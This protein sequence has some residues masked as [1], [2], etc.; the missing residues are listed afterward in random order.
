MRRFVERARKGQRGQV[1]P[2]FALMALM[3]VGAVALAVDYG[4]LQDQHR[5]LQA[6]AD[7]AAIAG[8]E[9][10]TLD[11][12]SLPKARQSAMIYVRDNLGLPQSSFAL[13][14]SPGSA[15]CSNGTQGFSS[16]INNCQLPGNWSNYQVSIHSPGD[17]S[18]HVYGDTAPSLSVNIV[19]TVTNTVAAVMGVKTT[20]VGAFGE[21]KTQPPGVR[22]SAALYVDGCI[23]N[24]SALGSVL[25]VVVD[26]DVYLNDCTIANTGVTST[27]C[28]FP[29]PDSSGDIVYGPYANLPGNIL[30]LNLGL[31]C[32]VSI[33]GFG[34]S[35][36]SQF[37][38]PT[39]AFPNGLPG[40]PQSANVCGNEGDCTADHACKN[41][42]V[43]PAGAIPS[44]CYDPG[45]YSFANSTALRVKNNLN[46][47]VYYVDVSGGS[48]YTSTATNS[49]GGVFFEGNTMNANVNGVVGQ[50]WQQ[51]FPSLQVW[52]G[53]CPNG[54]I[55]D[56]TTP[57]DPQCAG[58]S[59]VDA[60]GHPAGFLN[61]PP[62]AYYSFTTAP[63]AGGVSGTLGANANYSVR[64]SALS[65][66]GETDAPTELSTT[67]NATG[68]LAVNITA[69]PN[70]TNGYKVYIGPPGQEQLAKTVA[71]AFS[72]PVNVTA[73]PAAG[74]QHYPLFNNSQCATG[75]HNIP[76]S[77]DQVPGTLAAP[78]QN[79]G[80]TFVLSGKASLC[81]GTWTTS[82]DWTC[83]P[84]SSAETVL[85]Q[86]YCA[87]G[88]GAG[89]PP[90]PPESQI[91]SDAGTAGANTEDG[92]YVVYSSG[93][94]AVRS[95]GGGSRL[96]MTGTVYAPRGSLIEDS[97]SSLTVTPGSIIVHDVSTG[98]NLSSVLAPLAYA[99]SSAGVFLPP[100]VNL[101]Q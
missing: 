6:F 93:L 24:T 39:S 47:G 23:N 34:V 65:A 8:A 45:V 78:N 74:A 28:A 63:A 83:N 31:G 16:N 95:S 20:N 13:S 4:F 98:L 48:C 100:G 17:Y 42:T 5:N 53:G 80:V 33:L 71:H 26:G 35:A 19:D 61:I 81:M 66:I 88:F 50:C 9:Q 58:S 21:A 57:L 86:P 99:S 69:S 68:A 32:T 7:H 52:T 76:H 82:S 44:N 11:G 85:L 89:S 49:C 84:T 3:I 72:N 38:L 101:V 2:I 92:S 73:L 36:G 75:F 30:P 94:G 97:G 96:G 70:E 62:A 54:Y 64:V 79:F 1:M 12:T 18:P 91:C 14:G 22:L 41:G 10:L 25:P 40:P 77:K 15:P 90:G 43:T 37:Q 56:P 46:P 60:K 51:G 29:T 67:S 59:A 55:Y 87:A 27:F